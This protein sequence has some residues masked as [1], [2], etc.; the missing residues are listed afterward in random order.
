MGWR[1]HRSVK[2]LPGVR[3]NF[4]K[5]STSISL[6]GR[7]FHKT[8][9]SSGRVT[10]TVGIPGT[11]LY[12]TESHSGHTRQP[13][14]TTVRTT[15]VAQYIPPQEI[16]TGPTVVQDVPAVD[17]N[18]IRTTIQNI[19]KEA[20]TPINWQEMLLS[21]LPDNQ[22]FHDKAENILDGDIDTYFKVINDLNPMADLME[23]GSEFECGT[24]DPRMLSVHFLVNS[25]AVLKDAK[26]LP[27][28]QYNDLL[29]DY[30]CGCAIRIARDIFALLPLRSV[31][32][33]ARDKNKEILSVEFTRKE[34]QKMDFAHIDA[35][36]TVSQFNHR[37]AF[38]LEKGF[39][40]IIP[41]DDKQGMN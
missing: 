12:Y 17:I 20:D 38:T 11:G 3:L 31:I 13:V 7:G 1:F 29:Q 40:T 27:I 24:D 23:Y 22:Y 36:D 14:R 4:N 39:M 37:M 9:S 6:G 16:Y 2:I 26:K 35:S 19:Y 28:T 8:I 32:V 25:D 5:S 30:V 34:F 15:R 41:I 10:N 21:T 33:D 18:Q